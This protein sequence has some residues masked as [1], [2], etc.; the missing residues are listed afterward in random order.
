MN[1]YQNRE[2]HKIFVSF[3]GSNAI[4]KK[5]I[6]MIVMIVVSFA[7]LPDG[8]SA[9]F[10][11]FFGGE[12]LKWEF[13]DG[14]ML[15]QI[16]GA[17]FMLYTV[18]K[19]IPK[20][21]ADVD[22]S[23][24]EAP[25]KAKALVL[26]LSKNDRADDDINLKTINDFKSNYKMPL[27]AINYHKDRL[28][29]IVLV[30]SKESFNQKDKFIKCAESIFGNHLSNMMD[31]KCI[32]S[33]E[34]AKDVYDCLEQ[35]YK[36]LK[37]SKIDEKEIVFDVTGGQKVVGIAGAIFAIPND[38]HLQYVSTTDYKVRYYDLTYEK[39]TN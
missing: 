7:W 37:D 21:V 11:K 26:F 33:L 15:C 28:E 27:V 13:K 19:M 14:T 38:R 8:L 36:D 16:L 10:D 24:N 3:L 1:K 2:L 22:I 17:I 6:A 23:I 9:L 39:D 31:T 18:M 12:F 34:M 25:K 20:K 29:K 5:G 32:D 35:I 30:C 4:S